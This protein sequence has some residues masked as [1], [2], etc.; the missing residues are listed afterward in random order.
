MVTEVNVGHS[1][2]MLRLI[3][4]IFLLF[5]FFMDLVPATYNLF[6]LVF[7]AAL[8]YTAVSRSCEPYKWI[9]FKTTSKTEP[10]SVDRAIEYL[11]GV[12]AFYLVILLLRFYLV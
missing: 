6:I 3:F 2:Q 7:S 5:V 9:G 10:L 1:D 11:V 12:A 4:S 8:M